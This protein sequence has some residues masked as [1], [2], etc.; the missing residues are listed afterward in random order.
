LAWDL[1]FL[2]RLRR[3]L[4]FLLSC[5]S[6]AVSR[7]TYRGQLRPTP[8][9]EQKDSRNVVKESVCVGLLDVL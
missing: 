4:N 3:T 6:I 5:H 2:G 1:Q 7:I 9:G 8:H